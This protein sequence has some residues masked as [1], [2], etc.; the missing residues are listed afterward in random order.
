MTKGSCREMRDQL[1]A[2][3]D[4]ELP[5]ESSR[6]IQAHLDA[7]PPCLGFSRMEIEFTRVVRARLTRH[8]PPAALMTNLKAGMDAID[9]LRDGRSSSDPDS[10][11]GGPWLRRLM[12]GLTA[13]ALGLALAVPIAQRYEPDLYDRARMLISGT[14]RVSA[15]L[16]C[17]ECDREGVSIEE[18]RHCHAPGH[19]T[20]LRCPGTGLWHLVAN[21]ATLPLMKDRQRRGE[22]VIV[23]GH[24]LADIHYVDARSVRLPP[25]I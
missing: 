16:V 3:L 12:Y 19:Q 24:W 15:T 25:G 7:C 17:V 10:R 4:E 21:D 23:E 11:P 14:E 1:A 13:A 20:G 8:E 18:Q 5:P 22:T 9:A 6:A 2:F